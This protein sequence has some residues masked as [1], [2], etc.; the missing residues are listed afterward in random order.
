MAFD[1]NFFV[2]KIDLLYVTELDDLL[3]TTQDLCLNSLLSLINPIINENI[4]GF[5]IL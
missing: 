4:K 3:L 5:V 1:Y 2:V